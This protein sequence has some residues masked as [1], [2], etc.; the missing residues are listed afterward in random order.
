METPL[1]FILFIVVYLIPVLMWASALVWAFFATPL[2]LIPIVKT[3]PSCERESLE[4][5]TIQQNEDK[6]GVTGM[7][8]ILRQ[9]RPV[10]VGKSV[11]LKKD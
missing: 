5:R 3:V 2:T 9:S 8:A 7:N 4:L 1:D 11:I 6:R 10:T